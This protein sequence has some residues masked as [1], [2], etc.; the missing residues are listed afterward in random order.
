V[1]GAGGAAYLHVQ[2]GDDEAK[3]TA[4]ILL[5]ALA[6]KTD[7]GIEAIYSRKELDKF[8]VDQ[9][10]EYMIEAKEGYC[11][12]DDYTNE[13]IVDLHALGQ[14]YATHG[15]SPEKPDYTSNLIISGSSIKAGYDIGEVSVIDIGPTIA[16]LLK[17]PFENVD[18]RALNEIFK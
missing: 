16:H 17:L 12:D 4:L 13:V 3:M 10:F 1:Q 5:E 6:K 18:G 14:K 7:Y 9:Q 11:F 2:Q 15:Y 8:Q